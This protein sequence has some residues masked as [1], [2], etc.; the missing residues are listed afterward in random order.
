M[1]TD[2]WQ[3]HEKIAQAFEVVGALEERGYSLALFGK[4]ALINDELGI[5]AAEPEAYLQDWRKALKR[6]KGPTYA[7]AIVLAACMATGYG[8]L[9]GTEEI[10]HPHSA[11]LERG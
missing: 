2:N 1:S 6:E 5:Y 4:G 11:G 10:Q 3:P 7:K 9:A 8:G